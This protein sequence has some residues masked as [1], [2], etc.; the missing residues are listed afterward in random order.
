MKPSFYISKTDAAAVPNLKGLHFE[1]WQDY[2]DTDRVTSG[3]ML[4]RFDGQ[5]RYFW[6]DAFKWSSEGAIGYSG[7]SRNQYCK[8]PKFWV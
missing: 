2:G 7:C 3:G 5:Q 8:L 1:D 4:Y 6:R